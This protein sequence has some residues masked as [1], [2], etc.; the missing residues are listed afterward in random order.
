[1]LV[2]VFSETVLIVGSVFCLT[3]FTELIDLTIV[4]WPPVGP[5]DIKQKRTNEQT[6]SA[7]IPSQRCVYHT[8]PELHLP[9]V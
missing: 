5:Q 4:C 7:C 9:D 6:Q 2:L 8:R 3:E 1:M